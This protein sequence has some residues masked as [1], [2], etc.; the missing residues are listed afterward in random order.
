MKNKLFLF[1]C[2]LSSIS[3]SQN[4]DSLGSGLTGPGADVRD[5]FVD[6]ATNLLYAVGSFEYAGNKQ[7][8]G[9]AVWNGIEW[10]SV[11]EGLGGQAAPVVAIAS[12]QGDLYATGY[13]YSGTIYTWNGQDWVSIMSNADGPVFELYSRDQYL[14][15]LGWF[16]SIGGIYAARIAKYDGNTWSAID[17][18]QWTEDSGPL[19][20]ALLYNGELYAAGWSYIWPYFEN[21]GRFDGSDWN[22]LA[23]G[24]IGGAHIKSLCIYQNKLIIG[25]DFAEASG[26]PSNSIVAWDGNDFHELGNGVDDIIIGVNDMVVYNN[27]LYV[28]GDFQTVDYGLPAEKIAIWDGQQWCGL[29]SQI[30][31]VPNCIAEYN[32]ELII[33]GNIDSIDG[34]HFNKIA[35][36]IAG[37]YVDTCGA[38]TGVA[39]NIPPHQNIFIS[40]NPFT[41]QTT[42]TFQNPKFKIQN[43][44]FQLFTTLGQKASI[45]YSVSENESNTIFHIDRG[46][47]SSGVYFFQIISD[48]EIVASGKIIAQ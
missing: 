43:L 28:A 29:G 42:I 5:L 36:W 30:E 17:D 8:N 14:Y 46:N 25:G 22:P 4:W 35:K 40:P 26:N 27:K 13:Y 20:A 23:T 9:V 48:Q 21:I 24:I 45:K 19:V 37:D 44:K 10:D 41:N 18:T 6:T 47:L 33:A 38:I 7:V 12:Y 39:E 1:F 15:A 34:V 3:Y 11:G 32:G 31:G 2:L 16:D